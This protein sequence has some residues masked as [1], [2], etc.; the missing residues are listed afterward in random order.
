MPGEEFIFRFT[1]PAASQAA[2]GE[3]FA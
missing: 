2:P 1:L 3:G